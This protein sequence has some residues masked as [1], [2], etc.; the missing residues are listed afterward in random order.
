MRKSAPRYAGSLAPR[1]LQESALGTRDVKV[2]RST[3]S[4]DHFFGLGL[5]LGLTVIGLGL[6]SGLIRVGLVVSKRS[7]AFLIN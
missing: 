4:R 5:G 1:R 2:S 7:F 6:V 3:W